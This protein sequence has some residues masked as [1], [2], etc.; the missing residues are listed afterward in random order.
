MERDRSLV[1]GNNSCD[2]RSM[3]LQRKNTLLLLLNVYYNTLNFEP[4]LNEE[5]S[6]SRKSYKGFQVHVEKV[7]DQLTELYINPT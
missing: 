2:I 5:R 1:Q 3:N 7:D 6:R 4:N